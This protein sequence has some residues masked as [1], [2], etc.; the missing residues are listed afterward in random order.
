M[1]ENVSCFIIKGDE[2]C[3]SRF[4]ASAVVRDYDH[5][6]IWLPG[7]R[8]LQSGMGTDFWVIFLQF[9]IANVNIFKF[10]IAELASSETK[11]EL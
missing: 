8:I 4:I 1:Q 6:F 9:C 3:L 2:T 10:Y 5:I 7:S 11:L